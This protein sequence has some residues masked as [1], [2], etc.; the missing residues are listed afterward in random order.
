[1]NHDRCASKQLKFQHAILFGWMTLLWT[2]C[3]ERKEVPSDPIANRISPSESTI[4]STAQQE[5]RFRFSDRTSWLD[6][7]F[8]YRNGEEAGLFSIVESLGGGVG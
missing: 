1:M 4:D 3:A 7:S 8:S 5:Y 6:R 2:S